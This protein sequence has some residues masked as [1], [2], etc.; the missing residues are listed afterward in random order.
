MSDNNYNSSPIILFVILLTIAVLVLLIVFSVVHAQ[1]QL[2]RLPDG[3]TAILPDPVAV[4]IA[5]QKP[6]VVSRADALARF[7]VLRNQVALSALERQEY[8][9]LVIALFTFTTYGDPPVCSFVPGD[10]CS[11]LWR[12][13]NENPR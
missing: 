4:V 10:E 12:E 6:V 5:N 9:A 1:T 11:A 8:S 7:K 13:W 3:R 2:T